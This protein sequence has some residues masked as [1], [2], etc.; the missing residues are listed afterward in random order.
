MIQLSKRIEMNMME[1]QVVTFG[2]NKEN[3][4][5]SPT[6]SRQQLRNQPT[7]A[8]PPKAKGAKPNLSGGFT[9]YLVEQGGEDKCWK[10]GGLHK[11]DYPNPPQA[12]TSNLSPNQSCSHYHAYGHDADHYFTLHLELCQVQP[13]NT[14]MLVRAKVVGRA[15]RGKG[16]TDKRLVIK[17][18]K[19]NPT[20][21]KL[22]LHYWRP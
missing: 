20:P 13:Y 18:A 5:N 22:G 16:A 14:N 15:K 10:C 7:K 9:S 2:F 1:E 4:N 8:T 11:K 12:T 19:A 6:P 21:W 3:P 17:P